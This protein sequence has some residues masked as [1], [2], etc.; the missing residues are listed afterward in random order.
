MRLILL[1][2]I[3]LLLLSGCSNK[4]T[5]ELVDATVAIKETTIVGF[6]STE[7]D[8]EMILPNI[9]SYNFSLKNIGVDA[10]GGYSKL[11]GSNYDEGLQVTLEPG[12]NL[13]TL[14]KE[15]LGVNIFEE[16]GRKLGAGET[17]KPILEPNELGEFTLDFILIEITENSGIKTPST[18]Q[19]QKLQEI[20]LDA[21]IIVSIK[22]KEIARFELSNKEF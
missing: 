20:A 21:T 17:S 1:C 6:S 19:L 12:E 3:I 8:G 13:L 2:V 14:S 18:K 7:Y 16:K 15:M 11:Q 4:I 5:L 22:D 9:L 10:V